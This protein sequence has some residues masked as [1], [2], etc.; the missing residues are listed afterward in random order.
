MSSVLFKRLRALAAPTCSLKLLQAS[1]GSGKSF[2][3][4]PFEARLDRENDGLLL[5]VLPAEAPPS[6]QEWRVTWTVQSLADASFSVSRVLRALHVNPSRSGTGRGGPPPLH[7][8][9]LVGLH[10]GHVRL[11]IFV[12]RSSLKGGPEWQQTDVG[13]LYVEDFMAKFQ[14]FV[15][16]LGWPS[17]G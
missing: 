15:P 11:G 7:V 3:E 17:Q 10:V 16:P 12:E 6:S 4:V 8:P 1:P 2:C 13:A 14:V 5:V 9:A